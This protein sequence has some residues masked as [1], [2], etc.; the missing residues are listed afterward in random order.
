MFAS[1]LVED[2]II[3]SFISAGL[4]WSALIWALEGIAPIITIR[5]VQIRTAQ[6]KAS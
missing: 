4:I 6:I 3:S 1:R 5:A 2:F